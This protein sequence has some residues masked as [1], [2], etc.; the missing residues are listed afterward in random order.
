MAV[1]DW[2]IGASVVWGILCRRVTVYR[3]IDH[4]VGHESI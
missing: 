2:D 3:P 4:E 1:S